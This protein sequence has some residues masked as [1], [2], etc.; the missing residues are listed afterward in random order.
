[1]L[2]QILGIILFAGGRERPWT[3]LFSPDSPSRIDEFLAL[4]PG[5][6]FRV[7]HELQSLIHVPEGE[8]DTVIRILHP[9][10]RRFLL[11]P[12]RSKEFFIDADARHAQTTLHCLRIVGQGLIQGLVRLSRVVEFSCFEWCFRCMQCGHYPDL[13]GEL[14]QFDLARW[15]DWAVTKSVALTRSSV[16]GDPVAQY[17]KV[18]DW[19]QCMVCWFYNY[20][21]NLSL[22]MM[23][24]LFSWAVY[25]KLTARGIQTTSAESLCRYPGLSRTFAWSISNH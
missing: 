23:Q 25:S 6:T 19:I 4:R 9:E 21:F 10:L 17:N 15:L 3:T 12:Q 22:I 24:G 2:L 8:D 16:T 5:D 11:D 20:Q 7:L 1:L 13:L 18:L 14:Y